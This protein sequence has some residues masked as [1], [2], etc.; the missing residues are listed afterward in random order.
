MEGLECQ[1]LQALIRGWYKNHVTMVCTRLK[2]RFRVDFCIEFQ[3]LNPVIC[4]GC[5]NYMEDLPANAPMSV[6]LD[7]IG[8]DS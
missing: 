1:E 6:P 2:A 5:E 4:K 7:E 3:S 8:Y